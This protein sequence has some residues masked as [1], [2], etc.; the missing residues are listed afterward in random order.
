MGLADRWAT[1]IVVAALSAAALTGLI[2]R[3]PIRAVTILVV[4]CPC[5]LV[6]ATP[7]AIM[8]A[9]GNATK[10]SFLVREGDA[11]ERLASVTQ[12]TFDKTGTLTFGAPEVQAAVPLAPEVSREDLYAW[13]AGAERL[14]E[15]PL[16]KAV[17]T[18]L[19]GGDR[20][21]APGAVGLPNAPRPGGGG[22]GGRPPDHRRQ[23]GAAGRGGRPG[24]GAAL[25]RRALFRGRLV[26][27]SASRRTAVRRASWPLADTVR[28]D[29]ADTVARVKAA[30]VT[31]VLLTGDHAGAARRIAGQLGITAFQAECLPED[32]L[33]FIDRSQAAGQP[34]CMVGGRRQRRPGAE[35]GPCGASPWAASAATSPWTRRT[36]P[37]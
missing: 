30:G 34:V 11:L 13:T 14:S 7:T 20:R 19:A 18:G 17:V 22:G 4:F 29:A 35:A 23:P 27:L 1:W 5:A 2:T 36:S 15:H 10:H 25:R 24:G 32:K 33:A 21:A 12:V 28:P 26:P 16:G 31:P 8:A 37:W 6:L 3:D 9:I